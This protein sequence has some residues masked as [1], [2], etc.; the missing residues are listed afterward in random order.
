MILHGPSSGKQAYGAPL[1]VYLGQFDRK[2][3][4]C[5][6]PCGYGVHKSKPASVHHI[7]AHWVYLCLRASCANS[8]TEKR[9]LAAIALDTVNDSA[10]KAYKL[11]G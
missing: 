4:W 9:A 11:D 5:E 10:G 1:E 3:Q 6:R 2:R 7:N 8:A